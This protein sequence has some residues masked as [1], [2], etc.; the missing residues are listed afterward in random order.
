MSHFRPFSGARGAL[1][2]TLAALLLTA[3]A[4]DQPP[5]RQATGMRPH[6]EDRARTEQQA[7]PAQAQARPTQEADTDAGDDSA[8]VVAVEIQRACQL[9]KGA[10]NV[11]RFAFD[12]AQLRPRGR[13]ILDDVANCLTAGRLQ[14][15][16]ISIVGRAD[17][18]GPEQYNQE[19]GLSRAEAARQY[20]I[21]QGVSE[22]QLVVRS[23]GEAGAE[24]N[25][26]ESWKLDRRVD[27]VLGESPT[28]DA[29]TPASGQGAPRT[30]PEAK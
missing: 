1:T 11:P 13:N 28:G 10:E 5:A 17:P 25:D 12:E 8:V 20:L 7:A 18:R 29:M 24:G 27:L 6:F 23:R 26:E 16:T 2:A 22:Q 3:C 30:D 19:L 9:P 14:N 15:R 21:R 4:K